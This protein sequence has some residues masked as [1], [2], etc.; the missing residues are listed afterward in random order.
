MDRLVVSDVRCVLPETVRIFLGRA[1][2]IENTSGRRWN[3]ATKKPEPCLVFG[4]GFLVINKQVGTANAP[5]GATVIVTGMLL[6]SD[7]EV[8]I[9]SMVVVPV[10]ARREALQVMVTFALPFAGGVTGFAE[11]VADT[12]LGNSLTLKS[13]AELNPLTLV[14]VSVVDTLPLSSTVNEAGDND[15]VKFFVPEE[16]FTVSATVVV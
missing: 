4:P 11:A 12:P 2:T 3:D 6:L 13:T 8:P 15:S 5:Q 1:H 16:A 14:T 9:N 7:P 10:G